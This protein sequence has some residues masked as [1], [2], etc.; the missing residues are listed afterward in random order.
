[1]LFSK[2]ILFSKL[3]QST[4]QIIS[5]YFLGLSTFFILRIVFLIFNHKESSGVSWILIS[6]AI[7]RGIQFDSV[8]CGM[9]LIL[10]WFILLPSIFFPGKESVFR[11]TAFFITN[12]FFILAFFAAFADMPLFAQ[13]GKR[14]SVA[15]LN[16]S[17][18]PGFILRL[19]FSSWQIILLIFIFIGSAYLYYRIR[20][21]RMQ[22]ISESSR[23]DFSKSRTIIISI[24]IGGLLM[25]AM[26]GRISLKSP[27]RWG[28][29]YFCTNTFANQLVLNPF[30]TFVTSTYESVAG[31]KMNYHFM[32]D[33]KANA[34]VA[35]NF[36][37]PIVPLGPG[38]SFPSTKRNVV[39]VI[40]ESMAGWK[41]GLYPN[42]L[43]WTNCLD[44]LS[45]E[46][47]FFSRFFSDGI[48]TFNGIYSTLTGNQSL[49]KTQPLGD[50]NMDFNPVS[51]ADILKQQGYSTI[52]FTTHDAEFD[53]M[54]GFMRGNGYDE[55]IGEHDYG[56][57]TGMN[58]MGVPDHLMFDFARKKINSI[59]ANGKPFLVSIMTGSDHE[60]FEIPDNISFKGRGNDAHENATRYAD[61][62]I[63]QFMSACKKESW[64]SNTVFVFVADH[65]GIPNGKAHDM[66]LAFHHIPCIMIGPGISPQVNSSLGTQADILPTIMGMF[67][68]N[69]TDSAMGIDLMKQ[70]R[71]KVYFSYDDETCV[72]DTGSFY[73]QREI[74]PH[75]FLL[76]KNENACERSENSV[77]VLADK[78]YLD[79]IL[80]TMDERFYHK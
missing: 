26:R 34:I 51:I 8:S 25:L 50:M 3:S 58:P 16:W 5:D 1:M 74:D 30:Y 10:P 37:A 18:S 71:S 11:K 68:F 69:Y 40:M 52:F 60:P 75:L 39:I 48:H 77:Q 43:H 63:G 22:E 66:Y 23:K 17:S 6:E 44:S 15:A 13:F 59:S 42:G 31:K 20:K 65:G 32:D 62:S 70:T 76:N 2:R 41:T 54:N 49:P 56:I 53:N 21:K 47:I 46:G 64:Y 55:V 72:L 73:V 19:I 38:N 33:E 57:S 24:L 79:A 35:E 78:N 27:I 80:Q 7:F 45:K 29:A 14:I 12:I 9:I 28:T 36:S 4:G 67:H 61:W